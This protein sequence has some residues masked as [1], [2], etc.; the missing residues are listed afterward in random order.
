[1][2]ISAHLY[3]EIL[4]NGG[5]ISTDTINAVLIKKARSIKTNRVKDLNSISNTAGL[6]GSESLYTLSIRHEIIQLITE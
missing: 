3:I 2:E 4:L 1:M 5:Y 6:S